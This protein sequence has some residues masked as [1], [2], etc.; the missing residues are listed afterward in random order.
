MG[1]PSEWVSVITASCGTAAD[2]WSETLVKLVVDATGVDRGGNRGLLA[3]VN[4]LWTSGDAGS[5]LTT[6]ATVSYVPSS[7]SDTL[8][9]E[10]KI[11]AR[12]YTQFY[13]AKS[14]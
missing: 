3:V 5:E 11:N 6:F 10:I 13:S 14:S 4:R 9:Q 8:L 12:N 2:C 1:A 7:Y